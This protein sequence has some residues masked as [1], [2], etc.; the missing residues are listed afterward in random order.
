MTTAWVLPAVLQLVFPIVLLAWQ[1]VRRERSGLGW[2][3]TTIAVGAYMVAALLAG[4]WLVAP[5][6]LAVAFLT[7]SLALSAMRCP[8]PLRFRASM[9]LPDRFVLVARAIAAVLALGLVW[10]AVESRRPP[11][12]TVDLVF[13]LR[14]GTYYIANGGRNILTNAHVMTLDPRYSK[15]RGQSHGVDIVKLNPAGYRAHGLGPHDPQR[16]EIFGDVVYAPCEGI[17]ARVED[18][19]PDLAPPDVDRTHL[20]GNFVLLECDDDVHVLLAHLRSASVRVHPGDYVTIITELGE[21]G[22]SGNSTE[23][24]LHIHAQRPARIWNPFIGDPL[25]IL[26]DGRYLVRNDRI[27]KVGP[28]GDNEID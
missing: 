19:L 8:W 27:V 24:H 15:H 1:A 7:G 10:V 12:Q 16:Y 5:Q 23:P 26:L 6:Y 22:N 2:I 18:W 11:A 9:S 3:L 21:V 17:V 28:F 14:D 13:P 20:P 4:L 25:P